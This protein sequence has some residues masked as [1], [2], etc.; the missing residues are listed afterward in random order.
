[1]RD[2][3]SGPRD[4]IDALGP[5]LPSVE[6]WVEDLNVLRDHEIPGRAIGRVTLLLLKYCRHPELWRRAMS[7]GDLWREAGQEVDFEVLIPLLHYIA[8]VSGSK[9]GLEVLRFFQGIFGQRAKEQ[10]MMYGEQLIE[11]GRREGQQHSLLRLL[12]RRFG[13]LPA[14][15]V[16][17]INTA[18]YEQ[19]N[20]WLDRLFAGSSLEDLLGETQH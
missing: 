16:E 18:T 15:Y 4:L 9:P 6:L 19:L 11:Q 20:Q 8:F 10:V 17:E 5:H 1:M 7:W 14:G 13:E 2:L 12:R 3:V